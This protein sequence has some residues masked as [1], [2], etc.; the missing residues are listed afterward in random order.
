VL[1]GGGVTGFGVPASTPA[2][3]C[4]NID[5]ALDRLRA[6]PSMS[7]RGLSAPGATRRLFDGDSALAVALLYDALRCYRGEKPL[8]SPAGVAPGAGGATTLT[9]PARIAATLGA[10]ATA[11]A[12]PPPTRII[13]GTSGSAT[14]RA[15]VAAAAAAAAPQLP[16]PP[17]P[18]PPSPS[19]FPPVS[20]L[21][22]SPPPTPPRSV[23]ALLGYDGTMAAPPAISTGTGA[24]SRAPAT[25]ASG[26][27]A[28][29]EVAVACAWLASL[30]IEVQRPAALSG[31][32]GAATEFSDGTLLVRIVET[33]ENLRGMRRG[34]IT[35]VDKAPRTNAARL[36]NI[37]R[38]LEVLRDNRSMPL[39]YLWSEL[40]LRDGEPRVVRGLLLHIRR[41]Y[42]FATL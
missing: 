13:M 40:A 7:R 23:H 15:A 38:V 17:S 12:H 21:S 11:S 31:D 36:A 5:K 41:A 27:S 42:G 16:P 32:A 18:S 2:I 19:P 35:G 29:H 10:A 8:P 14:I 26:P 3:A 37:R 9:S 1:G 34:G 39:D 33:C 4:A 25:L 20:A 22:L 6:L 30:G 24:T 28:G